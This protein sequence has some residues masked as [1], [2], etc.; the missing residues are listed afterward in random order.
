MIT[1]VEACWVLCFP[2]SIT[3]IVEKSKYKYFLL[4]MYWYDG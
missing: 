4:D 2:N 3:A 1:S